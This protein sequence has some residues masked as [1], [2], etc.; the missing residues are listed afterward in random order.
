MAN[1]RHTRQR[2][3]DL[4]IIEKLKSPELHYD[5]DDYEY[6]DLGELVLK[7]YVGTV[8]RNP[9]SANQHTP[10]PRQELTWKYYINSLASGIPNAKKAALQAGYTA[11][12]AGNVVNCKWFKEK[13]AALKRRN[14]LTRA[15]K[16]L[17]RVLHLDWND[18]KLVDGEKVE[19]VN[20]DKLK[21]VKDVSIFVAETLGKEAGYTKKI[22]EEK[23]VS[24]DIRIESVDYS[25]VI[26][27]PDESKQPIIDVI[28][29]E[30]KNE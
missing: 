1:K 23:N 20:I 15:E 3:K 29:E 22:E 4:E 6:N 13:K 9:N 24:H 18:M 7:K 21:V 25:K 28:S 11:T 26:D 30:I 8:N 17:S 14:M 16:N 5:E 12:F 19:E 2:S 27:L 10:D